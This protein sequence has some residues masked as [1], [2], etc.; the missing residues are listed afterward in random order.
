VQ[1][2]VTEILKYTNNEELISFLAQYADKH[3]DFYQALVSLFHPKRRTTSQVNYKKGIQE[4]FEDSYDGDDFRHAGQFIAYKL[5]AYIERAKSLTKL[6]CQ[7]EAITILLHII[8][9]IGE[10][11]EGYYDYD[12]DLGGV[13]GEAGELIAGMIETGLPNDLLERMTGEISKLLGN[14]NFYNYDLTDLEELLFLISL[15]T[16]NFDDGIRILDEALKKESDSFRTHSLVMAKIK[17]LENAGKKEEVENVISSYLHLPEIRKIRLKELTS[18]KQYEKALAL[19]DEGISLAKKKEHPGTVAD[20]KDEKLSVY[21]LMENKE[22]IIELAEDLF[23]TDR[24]SMDYYHT[25]KTA[26]PTEEWTNYLDNFLRKA[27]K[28]KRWGVGPVLAQIYIEEEYWGR[29]MDYVEKNILLGQYSSLREYESYLK[30]Q[31]PERM[32]AFYHKQIMDYAEKN[33]GREHYR[34]VADVLK[35]MKEYPG[36]NEVVNALLTHFKSV[37]FRRRAMMEELKR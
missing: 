24:E 29:L 12:G 32:L 4:C 5:D 1:E 8:R 35:T 26:V 11:Y 30:P 37:Y 21:R 18:E 19:I 36:G 33:M 2:E 10:G 25:L 14:N 20:W 15:K 28:Q 23:F 13:C 7:E 17:F 31:Y 16:S 3:P 6:N 22:K 34:Y 27:T 9:E